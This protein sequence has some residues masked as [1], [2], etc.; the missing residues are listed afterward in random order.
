ML[1][2]ICSFIKNVAISAFKVMK[3]FVT[4]TV[5]NAEAVTILVFSSIGLT[6]VLTE[7]PFHITVPMWIEAPLIIPF[8]STLTIFLLVL[9]IQWRTGYESTV[10]SR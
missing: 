5:S 7:L 8:I 2:K 6:S 10:Y 4:E 3:D 9:C 1:R